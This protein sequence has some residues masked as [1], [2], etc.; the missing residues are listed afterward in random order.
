VLR[1]LGDDAAT[2]IA[3]GADLYVRN[4]KRFASGMK[5]VA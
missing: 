3:A 2:A 5:P 4:F 1:T